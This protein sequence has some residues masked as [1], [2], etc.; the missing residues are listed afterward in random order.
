MGG[1]KYMKTIFNGVLCSL[2]TFLRGDRR[3]G[4]CIYVLPTLYYLY[5]F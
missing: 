5:N 2:P 1:E 3:D 4:K